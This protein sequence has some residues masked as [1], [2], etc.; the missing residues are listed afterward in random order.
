MPVKTCRHQGCADKDRPRGA[1]PLR[2][3]PTPP[4]IFFSSTP[5]R[6]ATAWRIRLASASLKAIRRS[7]SLA[8]AALRS[9]TEYFIWMGQKDRQP[10]ATPPDDTWF[11]YLLLCPDGS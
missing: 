1:L 8:G 7:S 11:V 6:R 2:R 9:S 3:K 4:K 10:K 5:F